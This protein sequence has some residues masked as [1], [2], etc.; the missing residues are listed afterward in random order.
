M[1]KHSPNTVVM[2]NLLANYLY[3]QQTQNNISIHLKTCFQ[4]SDESKTIINSLTS[5]SLASHVV[6]KVHWLLGNLG[7]YSCLLGSMGE[8]VTKP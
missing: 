7:D 4:K 2:A 1:K 8:A 3:N 5:V 6:I